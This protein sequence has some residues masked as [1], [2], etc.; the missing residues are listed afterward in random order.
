MNK[1]GLIYGQ[2]FTTLSDIR[3]S[4]EHNHAS[5]E[6]SGNTS[7]GLMDQESQYVVHP[8]TLDG[9]LQFSIIAAH[10]GK[11]ESLKK[12]WLPVSFSKL[13]IWPHN[14]SP[15]SL[16][17]SCRGVQRGLRS[18]RATTT[19]STPDDQSIL[20]AEFSFSSL[21][22]G[23]DETKKSP[24]PYTRL[25]W[26]PDVDRLSNTQANNLFIGSEDKISTAKH[27]FSSLEE[28]TRLA[29]QSVVERLPT[30][31][32]VHQLPEHMQKFVSWM[33]AAES[34]LST[35]NPTALKGT[36]LIEK[37]NAIGQQFAE[38][39]PEAA[40]VAQLNA[41]M[42]EIMTGNIGALDVMVENNLLSRIYEDGFGQ[43][44]AYAKL[45]D[46]MELVAH[47]E[48]RLRI[49]ELGAGTGGAT[50]PMLKA[51]G[52]DTHMPK[53]ERYDFTDVSKAFLGVAQ[54]KFQ[55]YRHLEFGILDIESDPVDQGF[56]EHFYDIVFA[57]NVSLR[58]SSVGL[59]YFSDGFLG[60]PRHTQHRL[61]ASQLQEAP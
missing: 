7:E 3:S 10:Q 1:V 17:A 35:Q 34:T 20:K 57:S 51:L 48:P 18:V 47:K 37:I 19:L 36:Q 12:A 50:K 55:N 15:K 8:T 5:A 56:E 58:F 42:P 2:S 27:Y 28:I 14:T 40:M 38:D 49:L 26:K 11:A 22:K 61:F 52:G 53:Y 4:P 13:T 45:A 59:V 32:Q 30:D 31:L 39:V 44:G 24:Q 21:E 25:I 46:V 29:I 60:G 54:E 16:K 6:V 33:K 43:M 9:C 23:D 41:R